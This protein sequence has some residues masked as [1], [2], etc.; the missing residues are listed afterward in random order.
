MSKTSTK[1]TVFTNARIYT[2][3]AQLPLV[4]TLVVADGYIV[5]MGMY[6]NLRTH[7]SGADVNTVDLQ[8]R[9]VTPGLID[10]HV[11]LSWVGSNFLYLNLTG[12]QSKAE[13]LQRVR[14][15]AQSV[16]AG[17]WLV[18]L[19][20]DENLFGDGGI[21]AIEELDAVTPH[22]PVSL[23][24]V[25]GHAMLVNRQ[26]L[27]VCGVDAST[28]ILQGGSVVLDPATKA[29]TGLLLETASLLITPHIPEPTYDQL[30]S[31]LRQAVKL[32]LKSGLTGAHTEDLRYLGG[33]DQTYQMYDELIH[34]EDLGLRCN[35]LIDH[36]HMPH[37]K[38]RGMHAG[39][40]DDKL[41]IGAVKIFS[42][43]AFGRRT[44]L[45]S[46][47]YADSPQEHGVAVFSPEQLL[48]IVRQARA[49]S[50]PVAVHAI[51]DQAVQN[52]L[53]ALDAVGPVRYRD[54]V[55][56]AQL[57]RQDLLERLKGPNRIVD[58]QPR[59]VAS[60]FPWVMERLGQERMPF[61]YA[62]KTMM[63]NGVACAG[64][65]DSPVEPIQ[66]LLGIHAAV[67]RRAP[68]ERHEGWNPAERLSVLDALRLF[69]Q[70]GA[71][72]TNEEDVKGSLAPGKYADFTVYSQDI[73]AAQDAD[74]LLETQIEMT[75]I[76]GQVYYQKG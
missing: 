65:S 53:D 22:C 5:D 75:V 44:A 1:H 24:R 3:N 64:G 8:G 45:L 33:L 39:Y 52:V 36:Q 13:M 48:D 28:P 32:A 4:D 23:M 61:A 9:T 27:K 35:L 16:P 68:G 29:P 66:P 60:D 71:Y 70:G 6:E 11:H 50:M 73:V 17:E 72:A 37:L 20:W 38:A 58:I 42:D 67:T 30:K 69:T 2:L 31:S 43:G 56:H 18:G 25:C 21:P 49:L 19:G 74:V 54:R 10:S 62:W 26:A 46:Q 59:F 7:W 51:G 12:V 47:P 14:E 55:I 15:R 34:E 40:G 41:R 76:G 57:I 63:D